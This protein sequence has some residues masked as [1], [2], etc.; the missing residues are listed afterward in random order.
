[1]IERPSYL[2]RLQAWKDRDVIKVLTGMRRCGKSTIL[3]MFQDAL[4]ATGIE[5][6]CLI[7]LNFES[8]EENF[9]TGAKELYSY[10]A[11]RLS[12]NEKNYV[13][14]DEIQ[15][16]EHFEVV[17][18][19]LFV[20]KDVDLYITGSNSYFLSGELATLLTG[21]YVEIKVQPLSFKEYFNAVNSDRGG[22]DYPHNYPHGYGRP[23]F[24]KEEA[25]NRYLTYGGLPY[26][27]LLFDE[28]QLVEY[29]DGVFNTIFVTDILSRRPRMDMRAFKATTSFL[30]DN[31]GNI[32]SLKKIASGLAGT[33]SKVSEGAVREYV[34]ALLE[35]YLIYKAR[36]FDLKGR[37]H[38]KTLEKYYLG[39]L[40]FRFW[41]LG[42]DAGDIG[43]RIENV[44][45]LELLRKFLRVDIGKQGEKEIDFVAS[46]K[47]GPHY[48]QVAQT[49]LDENTLKRELEPLQNIKDN[50]PKTLLSLDVVGTGDFSGIHHMNLLEWLLGKETGV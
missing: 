14:L 16:I 42:K 38:L 1:M 37:A 27:A 13:F 40:G 30:A 50:Y 21:R 36:R 29:L 8:L 33:G 41:L 49:V 48:F 24:S 45:Y 35:C 5:E 4:K 17:A 31:I 11:S 7:A 22:F 12:A 15:R 39:D 23:A 25:F 47:D 10:I 44:V 19:A 20:R 43:H 9:P 6:K 46:D 18:D 32:S 34:D 28:R 2:E 3:E 26:A